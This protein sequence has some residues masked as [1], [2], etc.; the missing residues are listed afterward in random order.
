MIK[1]S[2]NEFYESIPKVYQNINGKIV[3]VKAEYVLEPEVYSIPLQTSKLKTK[4]LRQKT[5]NVT[6]KF[7]TFNTNYRL[8]IDPNTW[9]TYYGGN[10]T[11]AGNCITNDALGNVIFTGYSR[12]GNFP[13]SVGAFQTIL[14]DSSFDAFIVKLTPACVRLWATFYG[15]T[16]I[17]SGRGVITDGSDNVIVTGSTSSTNFPI[18]L[19]GTNLIHQE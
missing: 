4:N 1:T 16:G 2:I 6:F 3:N 19:S 14:S 11:E 12:S 18:G 7:S 15:G 10:N 8:I 13:K 17:E 5:Y 9:I